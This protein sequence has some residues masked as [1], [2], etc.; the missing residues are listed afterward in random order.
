MYSKI[1]KNGT[2]LSSKPAKE[3]LLGSREISVLLELK[4]GK[5]KFEIAKENNIKNSP[6][7]EIKILKKKTGDYFCSQILKDGKKKLKYCFYSV[8]TT[9]LLKN[10]V[11]TK[12]KQSRPKR[13]FYLKK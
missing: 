10:V 2:F 5:K 13:D 3:I 6:V 4:M 8:K 7:F 12:Y 1:L 9:N 11:G